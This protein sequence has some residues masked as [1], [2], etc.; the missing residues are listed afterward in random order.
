MLQYSGRASRSRAVTCTTIPCPFSNHC[1]MAEMSRSNAGVVDM[2]HGCWRMLLFTNPRSRCLGILG[3]RAYRRRCNS[4]RSYR[5]GRGIGSSIPA[6]PGQHH[7]CSLLK[8]AFMIL[9]TCINT[10]TDQPRRPILPRRLTN[11]HRQVLVEHYN[12]PLTRKQQQDMQPTRR[13]AATQS[14]VKERKIYMTRIKSAP[15]LAASPERRNVSDH[16]LWRS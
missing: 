7:Q 8:K 10:L 13:T 15:Q 1:E 3:V 5:L 2:H 12:H 4:A 6:V 14:I 16:M 11:V 9:H